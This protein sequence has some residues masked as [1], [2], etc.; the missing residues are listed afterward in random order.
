LIRDKEKSRCNILRV[1]TDPIGRANKEENW[2]YVKPVPNNVIINLG[3]AMVEWT[4]Q[5]LRSNEH[6][7]TFAPGNQAE[8]PRYSIAYLVRPEK[9]ISMKRLV[10]GYIPSAAEDGQEEVLM[11]A[12]EWEMKKAMALK[13]GADCAK[14][15]GGRDFK[16]SNG[17]IE[18][19]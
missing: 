8:H 19:I 12:E 11:S 9:T 18:V 14:S 13:N 5:L 15:K 10:G 7:V 16:I 1:L 4:G 3:D 6:R 17:A 2:Q